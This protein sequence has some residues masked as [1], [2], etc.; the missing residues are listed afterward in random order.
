MSVL[1]THEIE[2]VLTLMA[3]TASLAARVKRE[4]L[5]SKSAKLSEFYLPR[6]DLSI[7]LKISIEHI[8]AQ[9]LLTKIRE[10]C[11]NHVSL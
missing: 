6:T 1:H 5:L 11:K 8:T 3:L 9:N 10:S 2:G 4:R 7:R